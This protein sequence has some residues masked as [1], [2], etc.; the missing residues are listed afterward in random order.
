M[1]SAANSTSTLNSDLLAAM[2]AVGKAL[3]A[4][5][6]I[7]MP[8]DSEEYGVPM[9]LY[10]SCITVY[11]KLGSMI[12]EQSIATDQHDAADTLAGIGKVG[13]DAG[14]AAVGGDE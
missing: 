3:T 10:S 4:L 8:A 2:D 9:D 11:R 13:G 12:V 6:A 7:E 5:D 14:A 1:K